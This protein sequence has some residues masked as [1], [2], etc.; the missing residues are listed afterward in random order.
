MAPPITSLYGVLETQPY[1]KGK[2]YTLR[3]L[4]QLNIPYQWRFYDMFMEDL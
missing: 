2:E 4:W 3:E 1:I